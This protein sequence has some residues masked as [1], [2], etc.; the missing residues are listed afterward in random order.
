MC[1]SFS[2]PSTVFSTLKT[3]DDSCFQGSDSW[4]KVRKI[5]RVLGRLPVGGGIMLLLIIMTICWVI[6]IYQSL[7]DLC[8]LEMSFLACHP[9]ISLCVESGS[10]THRQLF[11]NGPA[12]SNYELH[13]SLQGTAPEPSPVP[14]PVSEW[15]S[16]SR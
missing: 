16:F 2:R 8:T 12:G 15:P 9:Y 5:D 11:L 7:C 13:F 1:I 14:P 10:S 6:T 3:L 4:R